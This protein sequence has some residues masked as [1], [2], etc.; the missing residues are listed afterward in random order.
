MNA[1]QPS[2]AYNFIDMNLPP[3]WIISATWPWLSRLRQSRNNLKLLWLRR[4]MMSN[5]HL[6]FSSEERNSLMNRCWRTFMQ[7]TAVILSINTPFKSMRSIA[8]AWLLLIQCNSSG[9]S[10]QQLQSSQLSFTYPSIATSLCPVDP[11]NKNLIVSF[12]RSASRPYK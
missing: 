4:V 10:G 2:I 12:I 8:M 1:A 5:K 9:V 6:I 11:I 7:P 3:I